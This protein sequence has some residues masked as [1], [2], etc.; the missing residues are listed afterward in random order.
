MFGRRDRRLSE[1]LRLDILDDVVP[2]PGGLLG[3]ELEFSVRSVRG[4][5]VHFGSLLHRLALDGTLLDPGDPN[6]Y[7]CSWGGVVTSDG[8]EA[9]IATPPVWTRPGFTAQLHAWARTGE[10]EL[11]RALPRGIGLDGYSAHFSAAMPAKLNDR[12]PA[13]RRDVRSGPDAADGSHRFL[14]ACWFVPARAAP[15]YVASSSRMSH[16]PQRRPLWLGA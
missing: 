11:R 16:L 14:Q 5:K 7:R 8:A 10:A 13:L 15:S 1:A 12:V 4:D 3:L 2:G 6:A 9:E